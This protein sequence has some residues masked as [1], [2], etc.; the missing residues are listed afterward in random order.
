M[1]VEKTYA[2]DGPTG[3]VSLLDLFEAR[4]QL[5]IYRAFFEPGVFG[6]PEHACRGCSLGADQVGHLAHLNVRDTTL[7]YASRC[8]ISWLTAAAVTPSSAA[9][10]VKLRRSATRRETGTRSNWPRGIVKPRLKAL[11]RYVALSGDRSSPGYVGDQI[12]GPFRR[13]S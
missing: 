10:A 8:L 13:V 5:I 3:T 2:L 9:A 12:P 4:R 1:A 6:W 7:A 11:E